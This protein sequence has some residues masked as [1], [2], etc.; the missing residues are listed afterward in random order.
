M[1]A[2]RMFLAIRRNRRRCAAR[3]C[4][5]KGAALLP[6]RAKRRC[7]T[8]VELQ[9]AVLQMRALL[10]PGQALGG[11]SEFAKEYGDVAFCRRLLRRAGG[12]AK[13]ATD[14]YKVA[15]SWREKNR[16][17]IEGRRF[18]LG[19]DERVIGKDASGRAVLYMCMKNQMLAGAKCLDQKVVTMLKAVESLPEGV[20]GTVHIWDMHGQAFRMSDMNPAPLISMIQSQETYFCGRLHEVVIIGMPR[21]ASLLKDAVWPV[22]PERTRAKVR[23]LAD[24]PQ[25]LDHLRAALEADTAERVASAMAENRDPKVTLEQR[26]TNWVQANADGSVSRLASECA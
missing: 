21:M 17:L 16:A 20:E 18:A 22:V 8:H 26:R 10:E 12:N 13:K 25:A 11:L 14:K 3:A 1:L 7:T 4:S 2:I 23:F 9:E 5:H 15:L 24:G 6:R 19:S